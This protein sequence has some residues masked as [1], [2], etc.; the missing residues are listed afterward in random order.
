MKLLSLDLIA[1]GPFT[2]ESLKFLGGAEGLHLIYG[3][4]EAGKSAA[5]R[6]LQSLFYGI[7]ERTSDNFLHDNSKLRIGA[8]VRHSGGSELS[9]VRRK[10][11]RSTLLDPNEQALDDSSLQKYLSGVAEEVF[12]TM[13]GIDHKVLL[14]GGQELLANQGE[15]AHS[16][17]AAALGTGNLREAMK[18][19]DDEASAIFKPRGSA[20]I[21]SKLIAEHK[22][23]RNT[24]ADLSLPSGDW[25]DHTE[26]L[27][28]AQREADAVTEKL[29]ELRTAL[30]RLERLREAI[31][32]VLERNNLLRQL[33]YLGDIIV[34]AL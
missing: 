5:L 6:A 31:P 15:V 9:F 26:E 20:Q 10:G 34:L 12:A 27:E 14:S 18:E 21:I 32:I 13:F 11:R 28:R 7:P 8:T 4:N 29:A 30:A 25:K 23:L 1:F 16:L 33:Q 2:D 22:K 17:Y 3:P 24:I 19:L